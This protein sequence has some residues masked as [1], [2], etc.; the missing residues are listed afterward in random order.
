MQIHTIKDSP[1]NKVFRGW[2]QEENDE[3]AKF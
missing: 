2:K 3:Y 1:R